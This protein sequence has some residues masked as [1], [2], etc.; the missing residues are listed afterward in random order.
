M[1]IIYTLGTGSNW[2]NNEIRFSIRS[3]F[4]NLKGFRNIYIIGEKPDFLLYDTEIDGHSIFHMPFPDLYGHRNADGN[5]IAKLLHAAQ[6]D[7][8]SDDFIF[9]NDDNYFL[10][11]IRVEDVKPF[12]KGNINE[13][14]PQDF[15][16]IWGKRLGRTRMHLSQ[17]GINPLHFD[18][19]APFPMKKSL[20]IR[21]YMP[22]DF[23]T[24]IGLTVKSIYGS[25]HYP[26]APRMND[27]KVMFRA[28]FELKYIRARCTNCLYLAHN[29]DGLTSSMKYFL[30]ENFPVPSDF[31]ISPIDDKIINV[32]EWQFLKR[33]YEKGSQLFVKY[34]PLKKNLHKL[35]INNDTYLV[36]KKMNYHLEKIVR[37]L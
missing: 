29:D 34:Y 19:H 6:N 16:G 8:I 14:D 2:S 12:H 21:T 15:L 4:K 10:K 33:P 24:D 31:E 18:H 30:F 27:E 22:F 7:D 23:M 5:I 28:R 1:D 9:I 3:L 37:D 36:R 25:I 17:A 32:A 35:F 13:V 26:D 20:M 11:P